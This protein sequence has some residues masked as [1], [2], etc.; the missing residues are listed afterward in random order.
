MRAR[1]GLIATAGAIATL[2]LVVPALTGRSTESWLSDLSA[3]SRG[4]LD[5]T[6]RQP[7]GSAQSGSPTAAPAAAATVTVS[8]PIRRDIVE[9]DELTGRFDAMETVDLRAR[10]TGYLQDVLFKDGQEVAKGDTLFIIDP[11][12]AERALAQAKAELEQA[13]TRIGNASLDVERA[14]PLVQRRVVSEKVFDDRENL[15]REAESAARVAEEKVKSAELDLSF[16]KVIAPVGG[17]IG[18]AQVTPGNY[19]TA[20]GTTGV[21]TLATI[22]SQDPIYLYFDIPEV[23]ALKYKRLA[24]RGAGV[25]AKTGAR[26]EAALPDEKGYPHSGR[27]DFLDNRLDAATGSLRARAVLDNKAR[28]FTPGLFARVRLQGSESYNATLVPD[29]AVGADQGNRYVLVV[30]P[31]DIPVRKSVK[32]G[33]L[34]DGLRVVREGLGADDWIV[35]RGLTRVRPGQKV[36][37][38]R[39]PLKVSEGAQ[40]LGGVTR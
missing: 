17:R 33:P 13:K 24:E 30:G 1:T 37:P 39:E 3:A 2:V 14:R 34:V 16:T 25:A 22:V 20:G 4:F 12:P 10:V 6:L 8:Q 40:P 26:I 29:E 18:R 27:V 19:V 38:K 36:A 28:L 21:T 31:D 7:S 15:Q 23:D 35:T 11:R 9:W 5:N 32:L